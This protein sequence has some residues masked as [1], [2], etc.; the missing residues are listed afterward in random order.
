VTS[1]GNQAADSPRQ[2]FKQFRFGDVRY[3]LSAR[4]GKLV[5]KLPSLFLKDA[6]FFRNSGCQLMVK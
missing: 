4:V 5:L 6:I 3:R 2:L 1:A